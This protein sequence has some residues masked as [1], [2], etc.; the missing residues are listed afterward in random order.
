MTMPAKLEIW[1]AVFTQF[2]KGHD[3]LNVDINISVEPRKISEKQINCGSRRYEL[4]KTR[5]KRCPT[6]AN[7]ANS[8]GPRV[9]GL[10]DADQSR[11]AGATLAHIVGLRRTGVFLRSFLSG[12]ITIRVGG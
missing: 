3:L 7:K 12:T 6:T 9:S 1:N 10:I 2:A 5:H 8:R 11:K 4:I